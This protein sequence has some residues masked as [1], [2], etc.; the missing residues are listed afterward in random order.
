M[1]TLWRDDDPYGKRQVYAALAQVPV[2]VCRGCSFF[3]LAPEGGLATRQPGT[4]C[5]GLKEGD[6]IS[7]SPQ[8]I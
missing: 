3:I 2:E 7:G 8:C 6:N 1:A 4:C 5:F